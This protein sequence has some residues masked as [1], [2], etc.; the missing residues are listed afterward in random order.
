MVSMGKPVRNLL[1]VFPVFLSRK[2]PEVR[3]VIHG[4]IRF[5]SPAKIPLEIF[6]GKQYPNWLPRRLT[7]SR[8]K[9]DMN[10]MNRTS[11][12]REKSRRGFRP[13]ESFLLVR[14]FGRIRIRRSVDQRVRLVPRKSPVRTEAN[15][16]APS[17]V[18]GKCTTFA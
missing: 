2:F 4:C 1:R 12:R 15:P 10:D 5:E 11:V 18:T 3:Y 8:N 7:V 17:Y 9:D 14:R 13:G 16:T 6:H